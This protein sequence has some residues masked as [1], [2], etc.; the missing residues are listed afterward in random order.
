[1]NFLKKY[2]W[3]II[4]FIGWIIVRFGFDF[5]GLYGQDAYAYLLHAREWKN[6]FSGGET[7]GAFFWPPS[8]SIVSGMIELIVQS[9]FYAL[10][11]VS[12]G[13]LIGLGW[14]TDK[15]IRNAYPTHENARIGFVTL[16][17]L[18]SPYMF[19]LGVQAMSD[20]LAMFLL[21]ASF[22]HLWIYLNSESQKSLI[23]WSLTSALALTTRYPAV[24]VLAPT[25][26]FVGVHLLSK[27]QFGRVGLAFLVGLIPVSA[28]IW[29]KLESG[30]INS[31]IQTVILQNW[32]FTNFFQSEFQSADTHSK[33]LLPNLIFN[34]STAIHPGTLF[35]GIALIPF[36]LNGLKEDKFRLLILVSVIIYALFL[37]GI[38]FQNSRV[39][40]FSYPLIVMFLF[41]A[42]LSFIAWIKSKKLPLKVAL[43]ITVIVQIGLCVRALQPSIEYSRFES[44]LVSWVQSNHPKATIYT[45]A[46]SQL[47]PAHRTE[48]VIVQTF[49]SVLSSYEENS[50]LIFN[51]S[52][53]DFKI[54]H[55]IPH[56][57]WKK[58][59]ELM[60]VEEEKCW[61][62][63][64]CVYSLKSR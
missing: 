13:S 42:F 10:Q 23:L 3:G 63:G 18:L 28:A 61:P 19:R 12:V 6:F 41:P 36:S 50:I 37:S 26:A 21:T 22:Y 31:D 5:N 1:M 8:Y 20:M 47:F 46:Y 7:P 35:W 34:F 16:A 15:W 24:I 54:K 2:Y 51:E 55:T 29:W 9:E 64:W 17:L 49:D 44:V 48:N 43:L 38:P 45:S 4:P 32:S 11:L 57:N 39:M 62:N 58:A 30:G 25:M 14:I 59:N 27:Q 40:T 60:L 53:I 33:F 56:Q 52:L